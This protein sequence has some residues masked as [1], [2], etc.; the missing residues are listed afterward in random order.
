MLSV[1]WRTASWTVPRFAHRVDIIRK[2]SRAN[3]FGFHLHTHRFAWSVIASSM[4]RALLCCW[5]Y[6]T[7]RGGLTI[8]HPSAPL[9]AVALDLSLANNNFPVRGDLHES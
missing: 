4:L 9:A 3:L 6:I 2:V 5:T 1:V 8:G 7:N